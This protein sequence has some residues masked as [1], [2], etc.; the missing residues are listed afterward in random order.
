M[1]RGQ[2]YICP[3]CAYQ[4]SNKTHMHK[5]FT[6]LKKVCAATQADVEL[7]EEVKEYVLANR[8]YR[9]PPPPPTV[10][11]VINNNLMINNYIASLDTMSKL[12]MVMDQTSLRLKGLEQHLDRKFER[13]RERLGSRPRL[14]LELDSQELLNTIDTVSRTCDC[15]SEFN[16]MLDSKNNKLR[17]YEGQWENYMLDKG[18]AHLVLRIQEYYWDSYEE[19]LIHN[20]FHRPG[21]MQEAQRCTELL[22]EYYQFLACFQVNPYVNEKSDAELGLGDDDECYDTSD[23]LMEMYHKIRDD[24]KAG[25]IKARKKKVVD[26]LKRG[27]A[28]NIESLNSKVLELF[29]MDAAFKDRILA[30]ASHTQA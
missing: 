14:G 8:V 2:K 25:E 11:S 24:T 26:I 4:T 1:A 21:G 19:Y 16:L 7:T 29:N 17:V 13:T 18:M 5:H 28:S 20:I 10:A 23:G 3:R 30:G 15:L 22:K 27:T 6:G 9:A 12:D